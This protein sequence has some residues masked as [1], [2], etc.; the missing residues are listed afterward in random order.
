MA[1][2]SFWFLL[3]FQTVSWHLHVRFMADSSRIH[4]EFMPVSFSPKKSK[5]CQIHCHFHGSF[6]A[7]SHPSLTWVQSA[8]VHWKKLIQKEWVLVVDLFFFGWFQLSFLAMCQ[9]H[10]GFM[11]LSWHFHGAFFILIFVVFFLKKNPN[12]QLNPSQK[13][14]SSLNVRFIANSSRIHGA[15]M[16]LSWHFPVSFT[17]MSDS[18]RIHVTF[19]AVSWQ[20]HIQ[21]LPGHSLPKSIGK[22]IQKVGV[23]CRFG[24]LPNFSFIFGNM[25]D[26]CRF[27]G[28]F[29]ALSWRFLPSD[30]YCFSKQFH[31]TCMADSI[32][33]HGTFMALSWQFPG[34]FLALSPLG[35]F[36][37]AMKVPWKC[38]EFAKPRWNLNVRFCL[39]VSVY[40]FL[41]VVSV[42]WCYFHWWFL[43]FRLI[44]FFWGFLWSKYRVI[45]NT[46][47]TNPN[48]QL[49]FSW[50]I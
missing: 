9:I 30:F 11:A 49:V 39:F 24:F 32:H 28:P 13:W 31:G 1:L 18:S 44:N 10:V 12:Q 42:F 5:S 23:G 19:M 3:F 2:S 15:F 16:S 4:R 37:F 38:H 43:R 35:M 29:M 27:H 46:Q 47:T 26:S 40:F 33:F 25:S 8:K 41:F 6:M 20:L 21:A 17:A 7:L 22:V 36:G 14:P 50:C 45:R 48:P 34:T